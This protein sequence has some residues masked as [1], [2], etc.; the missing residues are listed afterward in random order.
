MPISR[1]KSTPLSRRGSVVMGLAFISA[2]LYPLA[3]AFGLATPKPGSVHAP[4]WTVG[5][6]G[7]CF[8]AMGVALLTPRM[9]GRMRGFLVGVPV[10][11]LALI[12]DWIA[13]GPG[14]RHFTG[15]MSFGGSSI[16]SHSDETSGRIA[17]GVAAIVLDLFAAWGWYRWV[18][19]ASG[20]DEDT[21]PADV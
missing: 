20:P 21:G 7:T 2:G 14:E 1:P 15:A 3:I 16:G 11:C 10:T 4:P 9:H 13:F 18:R 6:A 12:F 5:M 19:G 17:F 8:V